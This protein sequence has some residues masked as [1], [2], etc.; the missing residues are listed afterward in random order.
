MEAAKKAYEFLAANFNNRM[1]KFIFS[2]VCV[3]DNKIQL[4]N[5]DDDKYYHFEVIEKLKNNGKIKFTI[6]FYNGDVQKMSQFKKK[7]HTAIK[8]FIKQKKKIF[9]DKKGGRRSSTSSS[10]SKK[11]SSSSSPKY[12]YSKHTYKRSKYH[13]SL[14]S[15]DSS[16]SSPRYRFGRFRHHRSVLRDA[17]L[18]PYLTEPFISSYLYYPSIYSIDNTT[19]SIPQISGRIFGVANP[20]YMYIGCI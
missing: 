4:E 1:K 19:I 17:L 6:N 9:M 13:R 18:D 12:R 2:L 16:D 5:I 3:D 15:S 10:R 20:C 14:S 7:A 11:R 8:T